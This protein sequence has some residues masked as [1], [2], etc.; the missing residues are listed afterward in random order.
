MGDTTVCSWDEFIKKVAEIQKEY[1]FKQCGDQK[2]EDK[3]LFRGLGDAEW[4][5]LTTLE[6]YSTS[7]WRVLSYLD[8][9]RRCAHPI[10]SIS[11]Q[12]WDFPDLDML[13]SEIWRNP[14]EHHLALPG[15]LFCV[16]LR[17]HGFPSPLLDWTASPFIA[18]FFALEQTYPI[19]E[20]GSSARLRWYDTL[21]ECWTAEYLSSDA[22]LEHSQKALL[23]ARGTQF[24]QGSRI[25]RI[26]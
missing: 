23:A 2:I 9:V 11:G 6:R 25:I 7:E 8:I 12:D 16:H 4:P 26:P 5:L 22:L 19:G 10:E 20:R 17:H 1:G 18:A 15:L 3:V 21:E 14:N 13:Q 24:A